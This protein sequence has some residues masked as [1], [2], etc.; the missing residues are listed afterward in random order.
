[1]GSIDF[2]GRKVPIEQGDSLASA[3][4]RSGV[5]TFTRSLKHHRRRG[6][7][8]M[9]GDCPN[10]LIDVDGEPGFRACTTEARDGQKVKR[11]SGRPSADFDL[12]AVTD[13]AHKL[14]P[15]GFYYKTFIRPRWAWEFAERIIRRATGVGRLPVG[16]APSRKQARHVHPDVL[17]IGG[18]V[19]GLSAAVAAAERGETRPRLR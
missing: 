13:R 11:P 19:A 15:V 6:L 2:E 14:M 5:R 16:R 10:C 3:L 8:C 9:T 18:G 4:Y 17:V 1:M 7:Y 12:L